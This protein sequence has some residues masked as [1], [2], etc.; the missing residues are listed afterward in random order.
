MF[1]SEVVGLIIC[2][3]A[4]SPRLDRRLSLSAPTWRADVSGQDRPVRR[5][6]GSGAE[7][8]DAYVRWR[9]QGQDALEGK[10]TVE[11][12]LRLH[13]EEWLSSERLLVSHG[14]HV[15]WTEH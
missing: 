9:G 4:A 6:K 7:G 14:Y 3:A 12:Y 10:S 11:P 13:L 15:R 8:P 5:R 2:S 1:C